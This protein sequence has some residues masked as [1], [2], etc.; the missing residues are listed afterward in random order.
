MSKLEPH[1]GG[2]VL[3]VPPCEPHREGGILS[4]PPGEGNG[5]SIIE[6]SPVASS[7]SNVFVERGSQSME[8]QTRTIKM[9]FESNIGG[10]VPSDHNLIPWIVEYAAVSIN[11]GQVSADLRTFE[12]NTSELGRIGVRRKTTLEEQRGG[13]R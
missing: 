6:A 2:G 11:R 7:G 10:A 3:S 9:A 5:R 8:G 12:G 4:A 1:M 13:Q